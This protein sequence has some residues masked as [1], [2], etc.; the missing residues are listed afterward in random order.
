M[1]DLNKAVKDWARAYQ[2]Y[3]SYDEGNTLEMEAHLHEQIEEYIEEGMDEKAA[4][5]KAVEAFGPAEQVANEEFLNQKRPF[6]LVTFIKLAMLRNYFKTSLRTLAKN[7]TTSIINIFGLAM[8]IGISLI[9]YA[10]MDF[11]YGVDRFHK[12]VNKLYLST[13]YVNREGAEANYGKSPAPLAVMLKEGFSY[14]EK[15]TRIEDRHAIMKHG[16]QVFHEQIR[17]ADPSFLEMFTFPL[18]QGSKANLQDP[19]MVIL[20]Q[21]MAVKYFGNEEALGKQITMVLP[22]QQQK[23][24]IIGGIAE[25]F[26]ENHIIAFDFLINFEALKQT[27]P[28]FELNNWKNSIN[29]T[30]VMVNDPSQIPTL[31]ADMNKYREIQNAADP[32]WA[33]TAFDFVSLYDLHLASGPIRDDISYDGS[34]EGRIGLP[35]ISSLLL[36][37]AIINYINIAIVSVS[38]RLNEIGLRKVIGASRGNIIYQFLLENIV[39][40]LFSG[41]IGA[42][43]AYLVLLP[44]FNGITGRMLSL[45][46]LDPHLLSFIIGLLLFTG[47]AS[48]LYPALYISKFEVIQIFKGKVRFG[49]KNV[50]NKVFLVIQFVI[51]CIGI[52]GG[53]MFSQN[54]H[55]QAGR[56]WG[57]NPESIL[58]AKIDQPSDFQAL[59]SSFA[60]NPV[61][62]GIAGAADHMGKQNMQAVIQLPDQ[63]IEVRKLAVGEKYL[64]NLDLNFVQGRSFLPNSKGDDKSIIINTTLAEKLNVDE[65]PGFSVRM[66][67][68]NYTVVGIVEDFHFYNFYYPMRPFIFTLAQ[69]EDYQWI[70]LKARDGEEDAVFNEMK[71]TWEEL[72][73]TIPFEGGYQEDVWVGFFE[74]LFIQIEFTTAV[75]IIS[76]IIAALGLYGMVRLNIAGR[77]KEFSIRKVLGALS[78]DLARSIFRQYILLALLAIVMGAPLSYYLVRSLIVLM[79]PGQEGIGLL[80]VGVAVGIL[81]L[82]LVA[83][84]ASQTWKVSKSNPVQGLRVES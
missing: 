37:L 79:F 56:D 14:I 68:T 26:P 66:D 31:K 61:I 62:E 84:I 53:V 75:S 23:T 49:K 17:Y 9:T 74:E 69:P 64:E 44:W 83:V 3:Q 20:S 21:P 58:Y 47:I 22:D 32:D 43:L 76:A 16:T 30:F 77:A 46:M 10:F 45:D 57:Y 18:A 72:F 78:I 55:Y 81:L 33:I 1:F 48:G 36:L 13:F 2:R 27:Y 29:A 6:S 54:S 65:V 50:L 40:T 12:N 7:P 70:T 25:P 63:Q 34:L 67:S 24:F 80:S 19:G 5:H 59:E 41:L 28:A 8:A 73:P 15:V 71:T 60:K 52:T 35:V 42:V 39:L 82:V 38:K 4:F 11:E 51:A